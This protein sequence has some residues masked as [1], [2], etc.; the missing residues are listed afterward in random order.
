MTI[1]ESMEFIEDNVCHRMDWCSDT[2]CE[3]CGINEAL[4][5]LWEESVEKTYIYI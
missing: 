1:K 5:I 3:D 4:N 2:Q